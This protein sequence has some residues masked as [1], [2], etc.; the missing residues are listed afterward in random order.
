M[1]QNASSPEWRDDIAATR[2]LIHPPP[3][4]NLH[5]WKCTKEVNYVASKM[6]GQVRTPPHPIRQVWKKNKSGFRSVKKIN[7]SCFE[8]LLGK[9][10]TGVATTVLCFRKF[11]PTY[12][13]SAVAK[14][15]KTRRTRWNHAGR[16]IALVFHE[17]ARPCQVKQWNKNKHTFHV[18]IAR[19]NHKSL[20]HIFAINFRIFLCSIWAGA[21]GMFGV[22]VLW[23]NNLRASTTTQRWLTYFSK[24]MNYVAQ[25]CQQSDEKN[26][27]TWW[28]KWKKLD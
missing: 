19:S 8:S 20:Q 22:M 25:H 16:A 13:A 12:P 5:V 3:H 11:P 10:R 24:F 17:H 2:T 1:H 28:D 7:I 21:R 18:K 4:P 26:G 15:C 9:F 23:C 14:R 27:D 6:F